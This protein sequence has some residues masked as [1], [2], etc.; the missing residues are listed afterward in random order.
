MFLGVYW[1]QPVCPSVHVSVCV[2]NTTFCQSAG[3]STKSHLVTALVCPCTERKKRSI[4]K[5]FPKQSP[6][7]KDAENQVI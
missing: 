5:F 4:S 6:S 7:F 2:Q 1:N 3:R